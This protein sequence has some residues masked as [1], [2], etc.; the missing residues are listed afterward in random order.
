MFTPSLFPEDLDLV[1]AHTRDGWEE[2]HRQRLFI[3]GGMGY[4]GI[5][6]LESF[7][8]ANE[9]LDLRAEATVLPR[10]P[11]AF[12]RRAPHLTIAAVIRLHAGDVKDVD[13][14]EGEFP[15]VIHAATSTTPYQNRVRLFRMNYSNDGNARFPS[16]WTEDE[17]ARG[18]SERE[19]G[20][21]RWSRVGYP[22]GKH[23][24]RTGS[25][26]GNPDETYGFF[27]THQDHGNCAEC[28]RRP[29]DWDFDKS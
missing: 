3:A 17:N 22:R 2:L 5:W 29:G 6:L 27:K 11:V 15:F 28:R 24:S 26:I 20:E 18:E 12:A 9:K 21:L 16:D 23:A 19:L 14:P 1:L 8:W 13:F 10:N 7:L 25:R 4:F